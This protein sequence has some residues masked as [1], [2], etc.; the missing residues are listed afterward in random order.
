LAR[1]PVAGP[2][3]VPRRGLRRVALVGIDGSGKTTQAHRLAQAL[4]EAGVPA[5]YWRN[6]GGRRWLGR[7]A[8]RLGRADAQALLGRSGLLLAEVTLR[9]LA[10]ARALLRSHGQ[11]AVLDRYAACQYASIRAHG[12][13]RW[14]PLARLSYR[15]FP[16]PDV[17][18]LLA[19]RPAEAS[20]RIEARGEDTE[21]LDFLVRSAAAYR[22][23]PEAA[24]FVLID[25]DGPPDE[26]ADAIHRHLRPWLSAVAGDPPAT[27]TDLPV[28]R[29][30]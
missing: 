4:T 21:S 13:H 3:A 1:P 20:R 23:L 9:W 6:A 25:A 24:S 26:V 28:T 2:D 29:A 19:V 30:D 27:I 10:I 22:T 7:V 14:E 12:G 16:A 15:I 8:R 5:R 11:V 17:T 18:F